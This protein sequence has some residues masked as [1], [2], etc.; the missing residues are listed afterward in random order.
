[1]L[2]M[3]DP[4]ESL[5]FVYDTLRQGEPLHAQLGESRFIA[6][7]STLPAFWLVDLGPYAGLLR[8]GSTAVVG[9][10]YAVSR[11]TRRH[12]DVER[13]VPLLFNRERLQLADGSE[14]EAYVLP[15]DKARGR[16]RLAQGD[17]KKR[18]SRPI[19]PSAGGAW[20][21]WSR[22]RWKA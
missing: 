9:E 14:A 18:F 11:Q 4:T 8:G 2:G 16:R 22:G 20:V 15:A 3:L 13:Q 1:M 19:N 12:L 17:W 5:L 6:E 10:L 7:A 21:A